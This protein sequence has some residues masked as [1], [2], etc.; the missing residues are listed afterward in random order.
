MFT[1]LYLYH[2]YRSVHCTEQGK[3]YQDC[4]CRCHASV[5][6]SYSRKR[7]AQISLGRAGRTVRLAKRPN[8]ILFGFGHFMHHTTDP[9]RW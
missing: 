1:H 8:Q 9:A 7:N 3:G 4:M 2:L 6:T 5:D